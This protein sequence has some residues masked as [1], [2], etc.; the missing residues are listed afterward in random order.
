MRYF[1]LARIDFCLFNSPLPAE[2]E[3]EEGGEE[4]VVQNE[5][6]SDSDPSA[7]PPPSRKKATARKPAQ[8]PKAANTKQKKASEKKTLAPVNP[9]RAKAELKKTGDQ[10][11]SDKAMVTEQK[12][13]A[14]RTKR[15]TTSK[16]QGEKGA[17][18]SKAKKT[19]VVVDR[20]AQ[21]EVIS[22]LDTALV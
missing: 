3:D 18:K 5:S 15:E 7:P 13:I 10:L 22:C 21:R 12:A 11:A 4:K 8:N 16:A 19:G 6:N 9:K 1:P 14:K 20:D 2:D 17:G